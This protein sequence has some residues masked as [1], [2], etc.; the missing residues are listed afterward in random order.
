M[1]LK[2]L[3]AIVPMLLLGWS[4][5]SI[6]QSNPSSLESPANGSNESGIGIIRGW[7]CEANQVTIQIDDF[8]ALEAAYGTDRNDTLSVC[9]DTKN[10]FG[11]TFN[12][13]LLNPGQHTVKALADGVE[14]GRA[15]FNV[16]NLGTRFLT[17]A[18]GNFALENFPSSGHTTAV[19]W[20]QANQNFIIGTANNSTTASGN[21]RQVLESP[22]NSSSESGISLIRGWACE[23]TG[24]AIKI[25]NYEPLPA[26]Y[27]TARAD[28]QAACGDINNGFGLIFNWNLL[29]DGQHTVI[30]YADGVEFARVS[31]NVTTLGSNFLTGASGDFLF[32]DFPVTGENSVVRWSEPHQN[33]IVIGYSG[34]NDTA[35]SGVWFLKTIDG[36][37]L[38]FPFTFVKANFGTSNIAITTNVPCNVDVAYVTVSNE[39]KGTV[40]N[41]EGVFC[42][43]GFGQQGT[44]RYEIS[45]ET[46]TVTGIDDQ[47][48]KVVSV[49]TRTQ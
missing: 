18:S 35:L 26:A 13:S 7:I 6:A 40:T 32:T 21:A 47:G 20:A 25:D 44:G 49:F 42:P 8:P 41:T 29:G 5:Y 14:F 37:P 28:T 15:T 12:W 4:S 16:T 45:G 9:G 1:L 48:Q 2:P 24:I 46:L 43:Q 39:I 36:K 17:G 34:Y 27:G 33:F 22:Q 10:S 38:P 30:A 31:F 19:S 23:A 11:L 3:V